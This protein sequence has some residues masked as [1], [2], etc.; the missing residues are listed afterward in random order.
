MAQSCKIIKRTHSLNSKSE[1]S[2]LQ[3]L[4]IHLL[5]YGAPDKPNFKEAAKVAWD[6]KYDKSQTMW[7]E[8]LLTPSAKARVTGY[9]PV[10]VGCKLYFSSLVEA[11]P[12]IQ[13]PDTHDNEHMISSS[14][15][16]RLGPPPLLETPQLSHCD[17]PSCCIYENIVIANSG[18]VLTLRGALF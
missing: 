8:L 18:W 11:I 9:L 3:S 15:S 12:G 10:R 7:M 2:G 6:N 16:P 14:S 13:N 1:L 5:N 17:T 4:D